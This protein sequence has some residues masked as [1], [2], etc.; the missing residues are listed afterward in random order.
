MLP[1]FKQEDLY[2][3][4]LGLPENL[5]GEIIN[6][7]FHVQPRPAGPHALVSS[8]LEIDI[9][10]AYHKGRGGPGGWWILVEPEVHFIRDIE[11][12]VPDIAG[13][14][15]ERMPRMPEDQRFEVV[16]DWVCEVLSPTTA[17]KDR[18]QKMPVYARYGVN[19]LWLVDPLART[20]EAF[21]LQEGRWVISGAFKDDDQVSAP[22]FA[23]IVLDLTEL[24]VGE[25]H[26]G[27]L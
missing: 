4:L 25:S 1:N 10:S 3:Q 20:L 18:I 24:W 21:E 5:V 26:P 15:R 7:Q 19:F 11:V 8:S 27:D 22:P 16:P 17:K 9:G 12:L 2:T 23:E 14:R 13:W 6:G